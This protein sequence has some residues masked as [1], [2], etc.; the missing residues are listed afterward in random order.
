MEYI[1]LLNEINEYLDSK[2]Q[3][4]L[5]IADM[6]SENEFNNYNFLYYYYVGISEE[7]IK[8][9][10]LTIMKK[11][12]LLKLI[13]HRSDKINRYIENLL[14][15]RNVKNL[16]SF[17]KI[18]LIHI[19]DLYNKKLRI[20]EIL[21]ILKKMKSI[22]YIELVHII[23]VDISFINTQLELIRR[24]K[25]NVSVE[26]S[27]ENKKYNF[28]I[29][30]TKVSVNEL[31]ESS[32]FYKRLID[33]SVEEILELNINPI[34]KEIILE[35]LRIRKNHTNKILKKILKLDL[36]ITDKTFSYKYARYIDLYQLSELNLS[37]KKLSL[38]LIMLKN[39]F[40]QELEL[41]LLKRK[42]LIKNINFI[43]SNLEL[44]K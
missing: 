2:L 44:L 42:D 28:L 30:V 38:L 29:Y 16:M 26:Y 39:T 36:D 11:E 31:K 34:K 8:N 19:T 7:Q 10:H 21:F 25:N 40:E 32:F 13:K 24:I 43:N 27:P 35:V 22:F 3:K 14:D 4:L 41:L 5:C 18:K 9:S 6:I 17:D 12:I 33:F 23:D 37:T 20:N 15:S 1:D